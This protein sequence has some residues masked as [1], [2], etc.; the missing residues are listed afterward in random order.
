MTTRVADGL[1][2]EKPFPWGKKLL[3][4]IILLVKEYRF[5]HLPVFSFVFDWFFLFFNHPK[6]RAF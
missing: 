5:P 2:F 6:T 3:P 4:D 1:L